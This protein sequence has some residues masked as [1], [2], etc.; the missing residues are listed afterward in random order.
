MQCPLCD[1]MWGL[2][3]HTCM[4]VCMSACVGPV[5]VLDAWM[6]I[7]GPVLVLDAWMDIGGPSTATACTRSVVE[8]IERQIHG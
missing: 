7:G 6:D 5:L 8:L 2:C 3:M 1:Y 4:H